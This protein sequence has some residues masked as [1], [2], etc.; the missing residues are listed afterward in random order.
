MAR[1]EIPGTGGKKFYSDSDGDSRP[2]TDQTVYEK[3]SSGRA[4]RVPN[5]RYNPNT[6]ETTKK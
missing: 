1:K 2:S 6:G 3:D 5:E 4:V